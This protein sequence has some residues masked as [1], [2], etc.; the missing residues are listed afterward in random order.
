MVLWSA[1]DERLTKLSDNVIMI[2]RGTV[3]G[4]SENGVVIVNLGDTSTLTAQA[5]NLAH[6][7][8]NNCATT[9][10]DIYCQ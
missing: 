7:T 2:E 3:S 8:Y 1:Q 6:G 10:G 9:G 5:I 4:A